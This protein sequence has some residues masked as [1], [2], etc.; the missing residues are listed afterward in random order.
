MTSLGISDFKWLRRILVLIGL[1]LLLLADPINQSIN[2]F[3]VIRHDRTH[4]YTREIEWSVSEK[5]LNRTTV[6]FSPRACVTLIS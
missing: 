4:T 2:H 3:I 1:L 6:A 5:Y